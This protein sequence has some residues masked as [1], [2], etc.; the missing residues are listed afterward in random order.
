MSP[1]PC[2]LAV[3][4]GLL[5]GT[6]AWAEAP[7]DSRTSRILAEVEGEAI[8]AETVE[9]ALG[10]RVHKLK[11]ELYRLQREKLDAMIAE[12][13]LEREA[14]RRGVSVE[15]LLEAE[16]TKV[17]VTDQEIAVF[18]REH[19]DSIQAK[20][21]AARDAIRK[22][23]EQQKRADQKSRF[24]DRLRAQAQVRD[25]LEAPEPIPY[26]FLVVPGAPIRG[27]K[28]APVTIVAF[29]DFQCPF[30]GQAHAVLLKVLEA[31]PKEVRLVVRYF[32]P[33]RRPQAK[34]AA[35][36]AQ[37]AAQQGR[38]WEYA[39]RLHA[40]ASDLDP[41]KVRAL[42]GELRLDPRV[43]GTCLDTGK[44]RARVAQDLTDGREAGVTGTP[45]FFINGRILEGA[46]PLAAFRKMIDQELAIGGRAGL[47]R[48]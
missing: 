2:T 15:R 26:D 31:Y 23:L 27:P 24:L 48:P 1:S 29:W 47:A 11:H 8:T 4:L 42:A 40:H 43:F 35:E 38:F 22:Y 13:L 37:C 36:A 28:H 3:A 17:S 6:A 46:Q 7:Q 20:E 19:K 21:A 32:P 12:K 30:C 10:Y 9:Q 41:A 34:L 25:Y 39:D 18:Y 5:L 16:V 45:T 14:T 33:A 44:A